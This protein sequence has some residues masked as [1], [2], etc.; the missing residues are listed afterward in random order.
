M[1]VVFVVVLCEMEE[2]IRVRVSLEKYNSLAREWNHR[3]DRN[4]TVTNI[5]LYMQTSLLILAMN[6]IANFV[7]GIKLTRSLAHC[8]QAT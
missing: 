2:G 5:C 7:V 4:C 3:A 8:N 1:T 6:V